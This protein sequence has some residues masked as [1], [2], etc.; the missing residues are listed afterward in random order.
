MVKVWGLFISSA[1]LLLP[2]A[3]L[4]LCMVPE[5]TG[6][7]KLKWSGPCISSTRVFLS[8]FPV[9]ASHVAE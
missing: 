3:T 9:C 7:S 5:R 2:D 8:P 1:A 6:T 4:G